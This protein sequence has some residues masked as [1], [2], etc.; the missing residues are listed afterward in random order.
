MTA[1][2]TVTPPGGVGGG[3]SRGQVL[4]FRRRAVKPPRRRRSLTLRLLKPLAGAV[5]L[6]GGP[7][8]LAVWALASPRFALADVAVTGSERVPAAWVRERLAPLT[9][10]N[11]LRLP[12]VDV[13]RALA[14]H[15]WIATVEVS[16]RLPDALAVTVVERR[17]A[18]L[19]VR[20][21][22]RWWADADGRAIA[23]V[24]E[25]EATGDLLLVTRAVGDGAVERPEGVAGWADTAPSDVPL[26][27]GLAG[28]LASCRPD[29]A[30]GLTWVEALSDD[31]A[32]LHSSALPFPLV[33]TAGR[34]APP[35]RRLAEL[36]PE[37]ARRYG[38]PAAVDLRFSRRIVIQP[39]AVSEDGQS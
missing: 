25:G 22:A 12:L 23:P 16:K 31:D 7:A 37:I 34:I 13:D 35:A 17:P 18:A 4:P 2:Y 24:G 33:V 8:G 9:G 26:A 30:A 5:A 14:G 36:L 1:L 15:P 29:W 19:V 20:G 38:Q 3:P 32:R 21:G 27:L 39:A 10:R 6:V 11:L 28:E